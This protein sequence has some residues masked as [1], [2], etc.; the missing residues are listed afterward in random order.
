VRTEKFYYPL[1]VNSFLNTT[2]ATSWM[3]VVV[4]SHPELKIW[5]NPSPRNLFFPKAKKSL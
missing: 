2:S 3:A 4:S 1:T 5:L